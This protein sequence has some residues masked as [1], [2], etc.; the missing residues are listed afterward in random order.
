M[1]A[2][3]NDFAAWT[4]RRLETSRESASRLRDVCFSALGNIAGTGRNFW[5]T[6]YE[7]TMEHVVEQ[8]VG[9]LIDCLLD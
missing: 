9:R 8:Q 1:Q 3:H 7:I 6:Q 4:P 2:C 5:V